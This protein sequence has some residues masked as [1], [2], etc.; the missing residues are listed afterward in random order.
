M[1]VRDLLAH[2]GADVAS[3]SQ[4]R[5][6]ADAMQLLRERGI[7]ALVVTGAGRPLVGIVSERDF[8]RAMATQGAAMLTM[9]VGELMSSDVV[10]CSSD[11]SV[12]HLMT[13]MT[14]ERIRHV[15][16][17]DDGQLRGIISIG[18]VVKMRLSELESDKQSLLDYV[19]SW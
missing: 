11:E 7:G 18:D 10:T 19:S 2:K 9:S 12:T 8:V 17:V 13:L 15:P 5:S 6:A 1:K 4:E 14:E 16:V 3:I